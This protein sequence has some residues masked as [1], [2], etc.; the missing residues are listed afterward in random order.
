MCSAVTFSMTAD[1]ENE[2][3]GESL[4]L[5]ILYCVYWSINTFYIGKQEMIKL[6]LR[7][8]F[9]YWIIN[10][11]DKHIITRYKQKLKASTLTKKSKTEHKQ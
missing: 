3:G 6:M 9:L 1:V 10:E 11:G 2:H 4:H 7:V 5:N 8:T